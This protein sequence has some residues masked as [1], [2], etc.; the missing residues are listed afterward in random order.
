MFQFT[1]FPSMRYG[2]A[3]GWLESVQPGFPIQRSMDQRIFAPPH[4][5][6]QLITSFFGSQ[7]QGIR[8]VLFL[9]WPS[10]YSV[11]SF[12]FLLYGFPYGSRFV[13]RMSDF[14]ENLFLKSFSVWS[15]QGTFY[16]FLTVLSA[17]RKQNPFYPL[18]TGKYQFLCH[19]L[20]A[21]F[22]CTG[23]HLLSHAVSSIVSSAA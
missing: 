6:S 2:L 16:C 3:H 12:L 18:I 10:I 7:C 22:F 14:F 8:P 19:Q 1:G 21:V 5:F 23:S 4:G 17:I 20:S 15:F 11:I 13:S 9:A